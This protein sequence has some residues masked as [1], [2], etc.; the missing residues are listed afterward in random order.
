[1]LE[2]YSTF[3]VYITQ[4]L[5]LVL[6]TD[7]RRTKLLLNQPKILTKQAHA[8]FHTDLGCT[9]RT[10]VTEHPDVFWKEHE[11]VNHR[12]HES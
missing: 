10:V 5:P 7:T 11:Q 8:S 9:L 6:V 1:M 12:T 3:C 4:V 2:V